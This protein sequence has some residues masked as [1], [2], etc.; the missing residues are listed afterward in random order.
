MEKVKIAKRSRRLAFVTFLCCLV[1][2][3]CVFASESIILVSGMENAYGP[4]PMLEPCILWRLDEKDHYRRQDQHHW[5]SIIC[6]G[7]SLVNA[8]DTAQAIINYERSLEINPENTN[9]VRTLEQLHK[10]WPPI[11]ADHKRYSHRMFTSYNSR[12]T[13]LF[14]IK[15]ACFLCGMLFANT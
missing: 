7:E 9:A 2:L 6:N 14:C 12:R 5:S 10:K 11:K 15:S 3:Q 13:V 1:F 8:G 4:N